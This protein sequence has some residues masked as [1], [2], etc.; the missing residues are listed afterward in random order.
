MVPVGCDE[1]G[2]SPPTGEV[3]SLQVAGQGVGC[4]VS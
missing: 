4:K 2:R 1:I 3:A